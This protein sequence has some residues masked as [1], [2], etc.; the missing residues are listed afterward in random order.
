MAHNDAIAIYFSQNF[1]SAAFLCYAP[2]I[3]L[4]EK[5]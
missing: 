5:K 4:L 1:H 3:D 2:I